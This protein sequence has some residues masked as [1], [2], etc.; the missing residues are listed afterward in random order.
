MPGYFS[1]IHI[2]FCNTISP[3]AGN[4]ITGLCRGILETRWGSL[5]PRLGKR[6]LESVTC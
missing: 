1:I 5:E 6:D 2:A 3:A 4:S